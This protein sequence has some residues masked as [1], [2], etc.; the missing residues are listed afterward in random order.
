MAQVQ[1]TRNQQGTFEMKEEV[2]ASAG[3]QDIDTSGYELSNSEQI[4]VFWENPQVE[5]EAVFKS[6]IDASFSPTVF[7]DL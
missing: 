7:N 4:D 2:L 3:A 6:E 5:W 1:I